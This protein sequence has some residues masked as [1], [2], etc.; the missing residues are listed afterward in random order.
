VSSASP[1]RNSSSDLRLLSAGAP[2]E[3]TS[4]ASNLA[5]AS[6]RTLVPCLPFLRTQFGAAPR[7]SDVPPYDHSLCHQQL[8]R[9]RN[10]QQDPHRKRQRPP[11]GE[12]KSHSPPGAASFKPLYLKTPH[13]ASQLPVLRSGRFRYSTRHIRTNQRKNVA[14]PEPAQPKPS[15]ESRNAADQTGRGPPGVSCDSQAMNQLR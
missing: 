5:R 13:T 6:A 14:C 1:P 4:P 11:H 10:R 7:L 12:N 3:S 8:K 9:K 15:Y 2:H